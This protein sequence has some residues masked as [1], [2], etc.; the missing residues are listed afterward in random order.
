MSASSRL[1]L[2]TNQNRND[3]NLNE[4]AFEDG[5]FPA[6][7]LSCDRRVPTD[8]TVIELFRSHFIDLVDLTSPQVELLI[9]R[10][11]ERVWLP[12]PS[13]KVCT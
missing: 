12:L 1:D 8:H 5:D 2:D 13:S 11:S 9:L 10:E 7:R 3:E 6:L 4:E